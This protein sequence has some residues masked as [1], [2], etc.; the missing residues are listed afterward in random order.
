MYQ[1]VLVYQG[2]W[3]TN[4]TQQGEHE[5]QAFGGAGNSHCCHRCSV[6]KKKMYIV[7]HEEL[8]GKC[9]NS[10]WTSLN[11]SGV[12]SKKKRKKKKEYKISALHCIT[13]E[14]IKIELNLKCHIT[15]SFYTHTYFSTSPFAQLN[16]AVCLFPGFLVCR[17]SHTYL[18][19][20][21]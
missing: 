12:I 2:T 14:I 11:S 6:S 9:T 3:K 17:N 21:L 10:S 19:L 20:L 5:E 15:M 8:N 7:K 4:Q 13:K 1:L 18:S 16:A